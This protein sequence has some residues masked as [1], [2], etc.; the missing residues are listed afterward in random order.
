MHL[1]FFIFMLASFFSMPAFA[2]SPQS[3]ETSP[4]RLI[5]LAAGLDE[6]LW[7]LCSRPDDKKKI[8]GL[9]PLAGQKEFSNLPTRDV[10]GIPHVTDSPEPIIALRPDAVFVAPYNRP[11]TIRFLKKAGIHVVET[12]DVKSIADIKFNIKLM[13][14]IIGRHDEALTIISIME[15][16]LANLPL[17]NPP[18]NGAKVTP[19]IL[20][21]EPTGY[22][23]GKETLF[24]DMVTHA[25]GT[26]LAS[27]LGINGWQKTSLERLSQLEPDWIVIPAQ[28]KDENK[29]RQQIKKQTG[30]KSLLAVKNERFIFV[31]PSQMMAT[32][33]KIIAAVQIIAQ[34]IEA[35]P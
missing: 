29:L 9:S 4:Q 26:N 23:M 32:S 14:Q 30:W 31:P 18:K 2:T 28:P 12:H 34:A 10:V 6:I 27:E 1:R 13:G 5:T 24:D 35:G 11:T 25:G 21:Y 20:G 15:R 33:Q 7:E 16:Q 3:T 17:K 8:V 22:L 19:R